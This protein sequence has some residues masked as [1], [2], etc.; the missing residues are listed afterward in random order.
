LSLSA[1]KL[2]NKNFNLLNDLIIFKKINQINRMKTIQKLVFAFVLLTS[3]YSFAQPYKS[4]IGVRLGFPAWVN[5]DFKHNFGPHWA[6]ELAAGANYRYAGLDVAGMYHFNI[7]KV[8]GLRW[9]LGLSVDAGGYFAPVH[10][11]YHGDPYYNYGSLSLGTSFFGGIEYTFPN[12]PL[13]LAF[14]LGPRL[15]I[16]PFGVYPEYARVGIAARYVFK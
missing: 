10:H 5:F 1:Q 12:I 11:N 7:K 4:A 8:E 15:P 6:I 13:N 14:D 16:F 9:Y 2:I 3:T